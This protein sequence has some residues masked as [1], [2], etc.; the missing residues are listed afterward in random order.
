MSKIPEDILNKFRKSEL[1]QVYSAFQELANLIEVLTFSEGELRSHIRILHVNPR[2]SNLCNNCIKIQSEGYI[3]FYYCH[4]Q[5]LR[6]GPNWWLITR[7]YDEASVTRLA[8][9]I[10]NLAH[11]P[12]MKQSTS[13]ALILPYLSVGVTSPGD[14][15]SLSSFAC[16]A[17]S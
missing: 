14:S 13:S 4:T 16:F 17:S 9:L 11:D 7:A 3:M 2:N 5:C 1:S 12:Y 8:S 10:V 6:H 15:F